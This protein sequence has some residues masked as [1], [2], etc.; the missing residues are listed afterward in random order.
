MTFKYLIIDH[1]GLPIPVIFSTL[2]RHDE[3]A[4]ALA[5]RVVGAGHVRLWAEGDDPKLEVCGRAG[6][7]NIDPTKEDAT[8]ILEDYQRFR[9]KAVAAVMEQIAQG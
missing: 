6:S 5:K 8:F 2:L 7:L 1:E 3:I 4:R 9:G